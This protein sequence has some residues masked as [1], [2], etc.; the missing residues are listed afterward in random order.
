[1]PRQKKAAPQAMAPDFSKEA[2]VEGRIEQQLVESRSSELQT[3]DMQYALDTEPYDY[4]RVLC[5]ARA[6]VSIHA[7]AALTLG[8]ACLLIKEHEPHGRF[9]TALA[10]IGLAPRT[11]QAYMLAAR[12]FGDESRKLVAGR[13]SSAKLIELCHESDEDIDSL[14]EGGTIAGQT[15]DDIERMTRD[16]LR[17]ALR[18]ARSDKV[19]TEEILEKKNKKLDDLARKLKGWDRMPIREKADEL[20][21]HL[22]EQEMAVLSELHKLQKLVSELQAAHDEARAAIDPDIASRMEQMVEALDGR[23]RELQDQVNG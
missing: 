20:M 21:R 11:A 7:Q 15:L 22:G 9:Q 6:A 4:A 1:M 12:R 19:A 13:L 16:E 2:P 17:A 5:F 10:E 18:E 23:V 3:I 14:A 8:R